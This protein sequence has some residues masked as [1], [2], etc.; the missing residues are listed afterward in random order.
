[1]NI[2]YTHSFIVNNENFY[3][4]I[5]SIRN[6][7]KEDDWCGIFLRG[8][9][10]ELGNQVY[11]TIENTS[12]LSDRIDIISLKDK[13]LIMA[14]DLG[15]ASVIQIDT[16]NR[17]EFYVNYFIP[18]NTNTEKTSL[19]KGI[20]TN[21]DKFATGDFTSTQETFCQDLSCLMKG[22]PT[23]LDMGMPNYSELISKA[24]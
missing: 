15:H 1:M 17:D 14:R 5:P 9:S 21:N 20:K 24:K 2:H 6:N 8:I 3:E 18:K 19:L 22:I 11:D 7:S 13:I 12:L 10:N 4:S 23:D 16:T